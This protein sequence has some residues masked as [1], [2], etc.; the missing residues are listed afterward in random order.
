MIYLETN[1]DKKATKILIEMKEINDVRNSSKGLVVSL[2]SEG[3]KF[4]PKLFDKIRNEGIEIKS[5]NLKKPSLD[6]VFIQY[7]GRGLRDENRE[8]NQIMSRMKMM[9]MSGGGH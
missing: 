4:M 2:K 6:D 7:T 8:Q 3:T 1:N 5:I 9:G